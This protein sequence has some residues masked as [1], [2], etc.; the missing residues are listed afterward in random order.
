MVKSSQDEFYNGEYSGSEFVVEN[1]ELNTEC[2]PYKQ[3]DTVII[4]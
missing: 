4:L 1:G 2:D 3:V